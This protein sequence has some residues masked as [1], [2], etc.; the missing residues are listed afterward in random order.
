MKFSKV[1]RTDYRPPPSA[2][3]SS[4]LERESQPR[5]RAAAWPKPSVD[6]ERAGHDKAARELSSGT[7]LAA[8]KDLGGRKAHNQRDPESRWVTGRLAALAREIDK[9]GLNRNPAAITFSGP[10]K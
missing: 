8:A 9:R 6:H 3:A 2:G 4:P 1:R 10:P 7:L 5:P